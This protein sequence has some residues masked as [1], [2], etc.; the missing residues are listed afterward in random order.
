VYGTPSFS[1]EKA[2][3]EIAAYNETERTEQTREIDEETVEQL[4]GMGYI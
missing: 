2:S 3:A 1:A 4:E